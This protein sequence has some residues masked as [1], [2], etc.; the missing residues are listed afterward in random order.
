MKD[1]WYYRAVLQKLGRYGLVSGVILLCI[2]YS[3]NSDFKTVHFTLKYEPLILTDTFIHKITYM[4]TI[5]L[6]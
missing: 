1:L 5:L 3:L 2:F 6:K 4:L